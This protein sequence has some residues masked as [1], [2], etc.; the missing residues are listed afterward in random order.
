M[1]GRGI[2]GAVA[3]AAA[4]A[5]LVG[6]PATA[7]A[8]IFVIDQRTVTHQTPPGC[9]SGSLCVYENANYTGALR[10]KDV[11]NDPNWKDNY[12]SNG[13]NLDNSATSIYNNS[14]SYSRRVFRDLNYGSYILC[15]SPNTGVKDL[16]QVEWI[17][18]PGDF[19][20]K[21]HNLNDQL[22]SHKSY[23][24]SIVDL[25]CNWRTTGRAQDTFEPGTPIPKVPGLEP[26]DLPPI[27]P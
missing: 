18:N 15:L 21:V 14:S 7:G 19:D 9:T 1:G 5:A 2:A 13:D 3:L 16:H 12:Y 6:V 17:S 20:T 8:E 4:M 10:I 23:T 22:S 27:E 24:E 25:N 11:L 26:I